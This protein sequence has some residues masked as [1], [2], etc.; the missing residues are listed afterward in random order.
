MQVLT[1]KEMF[2]GGDNDEFG[3]WVDTHHYASEKEAEDVK[4][5][6]EVSSVAVEVDFSSLILKW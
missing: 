4:N 3:D 5:I 6:E 2:E 1:N